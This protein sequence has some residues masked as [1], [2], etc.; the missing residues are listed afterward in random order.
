VSQGHVM[1]KNFTTPQQIAAQYSQSTANA[2]AQ[3]TTKYNYTLL[4]NAYNPYAQQ[5]YISSM[6]QTLHD[7]QLEKTY[8]VDG[9]WMSLEQF[10]NSIYPEDCAEK[11]FLILRL[12]GKQ[13]EDKS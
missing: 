11:T 7:W 3:S 10:V 6:K 13:N 4:Q 9:E 2:A 12:Q 1:P 5:G 8:C